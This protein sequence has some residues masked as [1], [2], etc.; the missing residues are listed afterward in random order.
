[1]NKSAATAAKIILLFLWLGLTARAAASLVTSQNSTLSVPSS[2]IATNV[3]PWATNLVGSKFML[4]SVVPNT[5]NGGCASLVNSL[6][7]MRQYHGGVYNSAYDMALR[8][9]GS[10]VV[11]GYSTG[12]MTDD[13]FCVLSYSPD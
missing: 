9:D 3:F 12:F 4:S 1:M 7:W 5:P 10:V 11:C 8:M 13:D 6:Q 2:R